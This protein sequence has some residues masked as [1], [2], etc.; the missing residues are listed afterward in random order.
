MPRRASSE[1][2]LDAQTEVPV[3]ATTTERQRALRRIAEL[4][5]PIAPRPL[6]DNDPILVAALSALLPAARASRMNI[7]DALRHHG[8]EV[9]VGHGDDDEADPLD[10]FGIQL[11]R[12]RSGYRMTTRGAKHDVRV[13]PA[14]VAPLAAHMIE[15]V[16][17]DLSKF[18]I[19][20]MPGLLVALHVSEGDEVQPGQPLATVEA[21]KME[22]ILRAEKSATVKA[23]PVGAGESVAVDQV[24]VEF[25]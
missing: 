14:H 15:K 10:T 25:E 8:R 24:I 17:P 4:Y 2:V 18:L 11:A 9:C 3:V 13:L 21:M 23:T 12:T 5:V 16:P 22:N 7:V 19:C 6:V 20:P 1:I